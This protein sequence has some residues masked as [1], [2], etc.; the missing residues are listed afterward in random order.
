VVLITF[1]HYIYFLPNNLFK[2]NVYYCFAKQHTSKMHV[3]GLDKYKHKQQKYLHIVYMCI[4]YTSL[5]K[6]YP[7]F[8]IN[9][10][11]LSRKKVLYTFKRKWL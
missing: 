1:I 2:L 5:M 10:V 11:Y 3:C 8:P 4:E 9:I 7:I 6:C